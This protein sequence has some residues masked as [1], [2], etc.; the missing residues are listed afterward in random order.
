MPIPPGFHALRKGPVAIVVSGPWKE[1]IEKLDLCHPGRIAAARSAGQGATGRGTTEI[2]QLMSPGVDQG[3]S[4]AQLVFRPMLH[5]GILSPL[6]GPTYLSSKRALNELYVTWALREA[7]APVP[8][9]VMAQVERRRF[10]F[11]LAMGTRLEENSVDGIGFL[12][13][14]PKPKRIY[15]VTHAIGQAVRRFHDAGGS[16]PDLHLKN[17]LIR[18]AAHDDS[19]PEVFIIDLDGA[20]KRQQVSPGRR[21]DELMR[22]YRSVIK[23]GYNQQLSGEP[24]RNFFDGYVG[25][26]T[27]LRDQLIARLPLERRKLSLRRASY[28]FRGWES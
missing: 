22:L 18:E 2:L 7:G 14:R 5:G 17:L 8:E 19:P 3:S 27:D 26:D 11:H 16:H 9:P 24:M 21:M 10:G 20:E 12:N 13:Q 23:R 6:L 15:T 28:R 25:E 1:C 4:Q